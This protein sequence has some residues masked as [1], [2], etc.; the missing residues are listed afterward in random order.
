MTFGKCLRP[1]LEGKGASST[2]G[3]QGDLG[4]RP[5]TGGAHP[6][7]RAPQVPGARHP[8]QPRRGEAVPANHVRQR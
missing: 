7:S 6:A 1:T 8:R 5:A 4:L 3:L 2:G